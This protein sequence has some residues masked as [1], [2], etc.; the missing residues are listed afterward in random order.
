MRE[1]LILWHLWYF[2]LFQDISGCAVIPQPFHQCIMCSK[3]NFHVSIKNV[4]DQ[5]SVAVKREYLCF[6]LKDEI[7]TMQKVN[8]ATMMKDFNFNCQCL[9]QGTWLWFSYVTTPCLKSGLFQF[10]LAQS[11][12]EYLMHILSQHMKHN[13]FKIHSSYI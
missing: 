3:E 9:V 10:S 11:W 2:S 1:S 5:S 12:A 13:I 6:Y 4:Q 8:H 7:A